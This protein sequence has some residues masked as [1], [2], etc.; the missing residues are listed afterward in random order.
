MEVV[1]GGL[2]VERWVGLGFVEGLISHGYSL[3]I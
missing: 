2:L 3:V 1:E